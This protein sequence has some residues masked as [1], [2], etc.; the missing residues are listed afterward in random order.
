MSEPFEPYRYA[1]LSG[2]QQA[3]EQIR[4]LE[5]KL[6]KETGHPVT[7]I[8]FEPTENKSESL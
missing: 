2:F 6:S 8:A 7:L 4:G 1:D 5:D 3:V